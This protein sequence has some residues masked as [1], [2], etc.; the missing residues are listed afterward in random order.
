[1]TQ[2]KPGMFSDQHAAGIRPQGM[3]MNSSSIELDAEKSGWLHAWL[4]S[5]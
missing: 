5:L 4:I 3:A 1:M 2:N